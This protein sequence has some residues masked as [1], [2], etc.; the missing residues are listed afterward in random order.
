MKRDFKIQKQG[1]KE[2]GGFFKRLFRG[3]R[4]R[5][6]MEKETKILWNNPTKN[7]EMAMETIDSKKTLWMIPR[8]L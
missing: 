3:R 7:P 1:G 5:V 4:K 2:K 6:G 8:K